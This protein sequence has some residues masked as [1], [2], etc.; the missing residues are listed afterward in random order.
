MPYPMAGAKALPSYP[1][2]AVRCSPEAQ[3]DPSVGTSPL[4]QELED[5]G[6]FARMERS[7]RRT[8]SSRGRTRS[9]QSSVRATRKPITTTS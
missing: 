9:L 1:M 3:P 4:A 7:I 6:F 2:G 8:V 5:S